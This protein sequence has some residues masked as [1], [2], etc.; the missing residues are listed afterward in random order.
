MMA[1]HHVRTN[2]C[3]D[4]VASGTRSEMVYQTNRSRSDTCR[5]GNQINPNRHEAGKGR[6]DILRCMRFRPVLRPILRQARR[7]VHES[8][9][10]P[11]RGRYEFGRLDFETNRPKPMRSIVWSSEMERLDEDRRPSR[12]RCHLRAAI[13]RRRLL[14]TNNNLQRTADVSP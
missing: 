5:S 13:I 8:D 3:T 11:I 2:R 9:P 6:S 14:P 12:A 1:S 4:A 10:R 7:P